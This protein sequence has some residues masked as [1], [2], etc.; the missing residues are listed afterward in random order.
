MF[1]FKKKKKPSTLFWQKLTYVSKKDDKISFFSKMVFYSQIRDRSF[2]RI[3]MQLLL[4][5]LR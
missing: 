5:L 1:L 4:L 2:A 3:Q